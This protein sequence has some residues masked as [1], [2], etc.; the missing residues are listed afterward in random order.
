MI[1][2]GFGISKPILCP[3]CRAPENVNPEEEM[4]S[5]YK[6]MAVNDA[7]SFDNLAGAYHAGSSFFGLQLDHKKA[8][9]LWSRS[10][11]LGSIDGHNSLGFAYMY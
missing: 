9:E 8:F 4:K 11:E 2:C 3:F 1:E 7:E 5:V 6:R 10:T